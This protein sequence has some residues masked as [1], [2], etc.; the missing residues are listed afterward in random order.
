MGK[1]KNTKLSSEDLEAVVSLNREKMELNDH[2]VRLGWAEVDLELGKKR[3]S[4]NAL[5]V[6]ETEAKLNRDLIE[7]YGIFKNLNLE[8]GEFELVEGSAPNK[9]SK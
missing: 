7:K 3:A 5:K 4:E 9:D 2:F 6:S 8:T 1:N